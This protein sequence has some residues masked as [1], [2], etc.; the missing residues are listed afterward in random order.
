VSQNVKEPALVYNH[1]SQ[2]YENVK[3]LVILYQFFHAYCKFFMDC[4]IARTDGS[5]ILEL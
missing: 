4:E 5:L 3:E 1:G 2:K